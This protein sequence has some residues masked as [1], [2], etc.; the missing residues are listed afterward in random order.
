MKEIWNKRGKSK[1]K[2][3]KKGRWKAGID[4]TGG[5]VRERRKREEISG[6]DRG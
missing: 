1:G 2:K 4:K 5:K 6:G 3:E